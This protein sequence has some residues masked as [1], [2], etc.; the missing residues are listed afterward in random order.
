MLLRLKTREVTYGIH[1]KDVSKFCS[2]YDT[3]ATECIFLTWPRTAIKVDLYRI[4]CQASATPCQEIKKKKVSKNKRSTCTFLFPDSCLF[5]HLVSNLSL[6]WKA[7][8]SQGWIL[9]STK[10]FVL[11]LHELSCLPHFQYTKKEKNNAQTC[12]VLTVN[13]SRGIM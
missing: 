6:T 9:H 3:T 8:V 5:L 4:S 12:E 2:P 10:L 7:N 1:L 13:G 11:F